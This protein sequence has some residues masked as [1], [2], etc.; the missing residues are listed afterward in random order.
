MAVLIYTFLFAQSVVFRH[1]FA[2]DGALH[3]VLGDDAMISMRHAR[4]WAHGLGPCYNGPPSACVEGYSNFLW[5]GFMGLVHLLPLDERLTSGVILGM[6]FLLGLAALIWLERLGAKLSPPGNRSGGASIFLALSSQFTFWGAAGFETTLL[7]LSTLG[8]VHFM[9]RGGWAGVGAS[10]AIGLLTRDDFLLVAVLVSGILALRRGASRGLS[11]KDWL[12]LA[13]L[14]VGAL[15]GHLA[16]RA[17]Y[18]GEL[19]PNT[20]YLKLTGWRLSARLLDGAAY[21]V[22][23]LPLAGIGTW[24]AVR[25][26]KSARAD[27]NT[28]LFGASG[29]LVVVLLPLVTCLYALWVG[30][31]AFLG[32]RLSAAS[33]PLTALGLAQVLPAFKGS[34]K[35]RAVAVLLGTLAFLGPWSRGSLGTLGTLREAMFWLGGRAGV[36]PRTGVAHGLLGRSFRGGQLVELPGP[37]K[38]VSLCHLIEGDAHE[39]QLNRPSIAV[40]YAGVLPYFCEDFRAIDVLGK[41]DRFV[42]RLPAGAGRVGHNKWDYAY[43][44]GELDADYF[45]SLVPS[46]ESLSDPAYRNLPEGDYNWHRVLHS[47]TFWSRCAEFAD[48][49]VRPLLFYCYRSRPAP[50]GLSPQLGGGRAR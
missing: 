32:A 45:A 29:Q 2:L 17:A 43:S 37:V 25:A 19:L 44:L 1:A 47:A 6:N 12:R 3:F 33:W 18:Y 50:A 5:T 4:N 36:L 27:G 10:L 20:Y 24:G 48:P 31:D 8:V 41:S 14:P 49:K 38:H 16:F 42:A 30:G 22:P 40:Y 26:W 11:R 13:L 39:H 21:V 34:N 15:A 9:L 23:L 35:V 28:G 7:S 46:T